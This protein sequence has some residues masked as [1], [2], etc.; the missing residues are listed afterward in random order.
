MERFTT[1]RMRVV[2]KPS[3]EKLIAI[4][5]DYIKWL[6]ITGGREAVDPYLS[7]LEEIL[8]EGP[9]EGD[10]ITIRLIVLGKRSI[11]F[12]PWTTEY[13]F[14]PRE[15][16]INIIFSNQGGTN[17]VVGKLTKDLIPPWR[18]TVWRRLPCARVHFAFID[19]SHHGGTSRWV[20]MSASVT[21]CGCFRRCH[22]RLFDGGMDST[23][24]GF[25]E[26]SIGSVHY[27]V[28][29]LRVNHVVESWDG[30]QEFVNTIFSSGFPFV[31]SKTTVRLQSSGEVLK[32]IPHDGI[33]AMIELL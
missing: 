6:K 29:K 4:N 32:R 18:D 21:N 26:Y 1:M 10:I 11:Y 13:P 24:K 17:N 20:K 28:W 9:K 15:D 22:M 23:P 33:A 2:E 3:L 8:A 16:P 12:Y 25:G 7:H 5:A 27:E 31:G 30:A 14:G 19:N